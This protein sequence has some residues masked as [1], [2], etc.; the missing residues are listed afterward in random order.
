[1]VSKYNYHIGR[2]RTR[3]ESKSA[4]SG[5][6]GGREQIVLRLGTRP[7][8]ECSTIEA[9]AKCC[10]K[11]CPIRVTQKRSFAQ[12]KTLESVEDII[13]RCSAEYL[14]KLKVHLLVSIECPEGFVWSCANTSNSSGCYSF[15]AFARMCS[16]YPV[17]T[18]SYKYTVIL[19]RFARLYLHVLLCFPWITRFARF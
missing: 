12:N 15:R 1:M 6:S 2:E 16:T 9:P 18:K 11:S 8:I 4:A 14:K 5:H 3:S 17:S 19:T 13:I 10:G 7:E